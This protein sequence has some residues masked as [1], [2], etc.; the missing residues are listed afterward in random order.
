MLGLSQ[1]YQLRGRVGRGKI[2][3]YAYL[4]LTH[5]KKTTKHSIQRLE[6][7]QNID[8][9]GAG[10]TITGHDMDLRGFGNLAGSEQSGHIKEVGAEL[11]QE[12]LDDAIEELKNKQKSIKF[13]ST[14]K[15]NIDVLIP[16]SYI[17]DLSLRLAI[18]RRTSNLETPTEIEKVP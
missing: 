3:G 5:C 12:M 7:L 1:L 6:I 4:I 14:I 10:F 8:F 13:T 9:L 15:L 11:Y 16:S 18:Y 17:E 2:K